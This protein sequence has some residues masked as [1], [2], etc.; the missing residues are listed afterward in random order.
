L[1]SLLTDLLLQGLENQQD[2]T[3]NKRL[4]DAIRLAILEGA[5]APGCRLPSSRDLA[6]QLS[7]SRNTVIA[8]YEQLLAEGYIETR[9]GS[10]TYVT[11]QLPSVTVPPLR[12][13]SEGAVRPAVQELSRRGMN[14]LGYTGASARQ[15][16]AFM[17]VKLI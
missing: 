16:G 12:D 6:Q 3:L 7:L 9:T 14:L 8:A 11:E 5:I 1:R 2:G 15:W 17:R 10:G 13:N 4:N